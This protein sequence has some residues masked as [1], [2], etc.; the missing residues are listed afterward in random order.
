MLLITLGPLLFMLLAF[1]LAGLG[2]SRTEAP[3]ILGRI[4]AAGIT[5]ALCAG[6]CRGLHERARDASR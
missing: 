2:P 3:G 4:F 1:V 6:R 5:T